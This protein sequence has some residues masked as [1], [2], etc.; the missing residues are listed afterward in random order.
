[1]YKLPRPDNNGKPKQ[2]NTSFSTVKI[3]LNFFLNF[4]QFYITYRDL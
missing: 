2:A 1:M 3:F 4:S